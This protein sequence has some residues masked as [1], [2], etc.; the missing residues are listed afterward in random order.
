MNLT[1]KKV[2]FPMNLTPKKVRFPINSALVLSD[3]SI[4]HSSMRRVEVEKFTPIL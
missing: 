4:F 3:Y 1:P 2:R